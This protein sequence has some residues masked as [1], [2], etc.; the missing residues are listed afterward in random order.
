MKKKT[1]ASTLSICGPQTNEK[2]QNNWDLARSKSLFEAVSM[3]IT[4]PSNTQILKI[5]FVQILILLY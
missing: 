3:V 2:P 4:A 1:P 5:R